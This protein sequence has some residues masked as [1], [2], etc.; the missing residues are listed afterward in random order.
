MP[1][2]VV[3]VMSTVPAAS[4]GT[5][6]VIDVALVTAKQG[7]PGHPDVTST[8]P[9]DTLAVVKTEPMKLVPVTVT[10]VPPLSGPLVGVMPIKIGAVTYVYWSALEV[11]FVPPGV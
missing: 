1:P 8:P 9:T 10:G 11:A 4:A 7:A 5:S 6:T 3:T 2:G